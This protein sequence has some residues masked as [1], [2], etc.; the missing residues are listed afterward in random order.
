MY[1]VDYSA[2]RN[3]Q[4]E[5]KGKGEREEGLAGGEVGQVPHSV[6]DP[7]IFQCNNVI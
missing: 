7:V 2:H 6:N 3:R 1:A 5:S 4:L